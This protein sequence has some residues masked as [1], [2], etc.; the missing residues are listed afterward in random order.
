METMKKCPFCAEEILAEAVKCK[1]CGS[2]VDGKQPETKVT[3]TGVDPFAEYHTPIQGKKKGKITVIGYMGIALGGLFVLVSCS[4]IG[5]A[6]DGGESGALIGL[7][8]IGIIV[9]SYFWA[10]R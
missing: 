3:V 9:G 4:V 6:Q 10:R 5:K 7:M 2:N 1:H 8:G